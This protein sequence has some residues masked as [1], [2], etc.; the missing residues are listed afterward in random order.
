M[1]ISG[2]LRFKRD[3]QVVSDRFKKREFVLTDNSSQYPQHVTFQ[4]TQDKCKLLDDISEGDTITV[5]FNLR[6]R[7]WKSPTGE[8]KFFNTLEAWK[9]DKSGDHSGYNQAA[10]DFEPSIQSA[11]KDD[12][13]F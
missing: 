11:P 12:L 6:G 3:E 9:I 10:P 7:E 2:V 1:Q 5:H 8:I 4:A 13:P